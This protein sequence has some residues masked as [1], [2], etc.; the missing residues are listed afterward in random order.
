V[1][2][3]EKDDAVNGFYLIR[4]LDSNVVWR[5]RLPFRAVD[6][7]KRGCHRKR[8]RPVKLRSAE[9]EELPPFTEEELRQLWLRRPCDDV[10]SNDDITIADFQMNI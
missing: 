6:Q 10:E 5:N 1:P 8:R 4:E 7:L 3:C 2:L 9:Q